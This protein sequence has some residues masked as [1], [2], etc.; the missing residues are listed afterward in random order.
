MKRKLFISALIVFALL[1][2]GAL[3]IALPFRTIRQLNIR[4][5]QA[6]RGMTVEQV[7]A[8]MAH[9]GGGAS[10]HWF[11]AWDDQQLPPAE[12]QRIA[13]ALRYSVRTF[14]LPV[15]FEFTFDSERRLIGR[16]IY[17]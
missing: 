1:A 8:L 3:Y 9:P 16:L 4:Y 10:E 15:S 12:A 11:A 13:S 17:D 6:Q 14:Y 7:E 5:H 2:C